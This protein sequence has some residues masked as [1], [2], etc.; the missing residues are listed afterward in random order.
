MTDPIDPIVHATAVSMI[1]AR[2]VMAI[3]TVRPDGWPH[4]TIVGYANDALTIY[5][6]IF[7]SSQKFRNIVN[8]DRVAIAIGEQPADIHL[9]EAVYAAGHA[10]EIIDPQE[11]EH[12]WRL[13]AKRHPNLAGRGMPDQSVTAIMGA[14]CEHVTVLDYSKGLGHTDALELPDR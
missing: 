7:K 11:R 12:A 1:D 13:L 5:F 2:R 4:N 6:L 10:A 14:T 9:A 8:N 3:A